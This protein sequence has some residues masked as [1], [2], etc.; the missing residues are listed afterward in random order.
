M[1]SSIF[2]T[3]VLAITRSRRWWLSASVGGVAALAAVWWL[4][5][6]RPM[7]ATLATLPWPAS[8]FRNTVP[9]V[10][11]VGSD[12]CVSC[13]PSHL[14]SLRRTGMG[15]SMAVVD[16]TVAPPDAE[17]DHP[18][19]KR[20]YTVVRKNGQLWHRETLLVDGKPV[21][22]LNDIPVKYVVGSG[23]HAQTFLAEIDG[24]LV[25]SPITWYAS[26][27]AW[28]MSP[29]YDRAEHAGFQRAISDNCLFC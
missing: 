27:R 21:A 7:P 15:R 9:G 20:R 28:F 24:F 4:G 5:R 18:V 25:E 29:G 16:P 17:F 19:S 11:Y 1:N 13:H 8:P 14:A 23:R 3:I 26:R 6:E 22:V 10:A 2:K 12:R